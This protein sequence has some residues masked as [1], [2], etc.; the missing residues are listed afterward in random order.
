MTPD[1]LHSD[2]AKPTAAGRIRRISFWI[3]AGITGVF[4]LVMLLPTY[5]LLFTNWL[6]ADAWLLVRPDRAPGDQIHRLH[7][8]ALAVI[9]WGA[10][11]GVALQFHRPHLKLGP[12]LMTLATV[13]GVGCGLA[14]TGTF[15]AAGMAP[16]LALP[17]VTCALHP[18][19]RVIAARPRLNLSM[20]AF[21]LLAAVPWVAYALNAAE[22]ARLA[23]PDGDMEHIGFMVIIAL[24]I[25]LWA[26]LGTARIPGWAFPA[27]AAILASAFVGLQSLIFQSALSALAPPWAMAA[28][29]W[30]VAYGGIAR[31]RSRQ[32]S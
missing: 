24:L 30:C 17:L 22:A 15:S 8:L 5:P 11:S 13:I 28:L 23:G 21:T 9:S 2:E 20:F 12:L 31:V 29:V 27:G 16:F 14:I 18:S 19:I 32:E 10:L 4:F 1:T 3:A 26:L 7:S 25:P 6:P